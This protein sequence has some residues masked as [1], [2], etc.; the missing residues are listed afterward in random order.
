[1]AFNEVFRARKK[2]ACDQCGEVIKPGQFYLR[3]DNPWT[4]ETVRVCHYC[5]KGI[6]RPKGLDQLRL[7]EKALGTK[8]EMKNISAGR[9]SVFLSHCHNDKR[10]VDKVADDLRKNGVNVWVDDAEIKLGDSFLEKISEGIHSVDYVAVFLSENSV[11]SEW[12]RK[13]LE[14]AM[15][16]EIKG[17]RVVVL[18]VLVESCQ[19]PPF[20]VGKLF[21]D[22]RNERKPG[23]ITKLILDRI[24][25]DT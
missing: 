10:I 21:A 6:Q 2:Y 19:I 1:M 13:E 8:E 24:Q 4:R 25:A 20:L 5:L 7:D 3:N 14:M 18:P 16:R 12:V 9:K 22:L 17:K 23:N 11:N 15:N